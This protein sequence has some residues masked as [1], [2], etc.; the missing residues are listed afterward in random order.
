MTPNNPTWRLLGTSA[1]GVT[2]WQR[3]HIRVGVSIYPGD[4]NGPEYV[5]SVSDAAG[6]NRL[7]GD[8]A[9]RRAL[10]DFGMADAHEDN[11]GPL[12]TCRTFWM[13]VDPSKREPCACHDEPVELTL[14]AGRPD[15]PG[16]LEWR[17]EKP[18]VTP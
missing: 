18:K 7:P 16:V 5:L 12:R 1:H 11:H 4:K 9:C 14:P 6:K 17:R 15:D 2:Y 8:K 3:H 13:A 10:V